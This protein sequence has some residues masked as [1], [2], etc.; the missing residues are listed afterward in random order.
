MKKKN[1][2]FVILISSFWFLNCCKKQEMTDPFWEI[3]LS[4]EKDKILK[5]L[6]EGS[7]SGEIT[8]CVFSFEKTTYVK[9]TNFDAKITCSLNNP[10]FNKNILE[11]LSYSLTVSFKNEQITQFSPDFY[12]Y[13]KNVMKSTYGDSLKE[14]YNDD[15][16]V[17]IWFLHGNKKVNVN[18]LKPINYY[19]VVV[20]I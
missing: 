4:W 3:N 13:F 17:L 11:K 14:N 15:E 8:N 19:S 20:N 10:Q 16:I 9:D 2:L 18:I 6:S 5:E 7:K 1:I 12:E